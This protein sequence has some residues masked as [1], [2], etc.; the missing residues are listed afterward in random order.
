VRPVLIVVGLV[1]TK[2]LSQM[3]L[4]PD[5]GAVVHSPVEWRVTPRM[6]MRRVACEPWVVMACDGTVDH[7]LLTPGFR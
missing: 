1:L 7:C 2:D 5:E 3:G 6:R 4:V